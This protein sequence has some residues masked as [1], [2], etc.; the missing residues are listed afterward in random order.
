MVT[1]WLG[2]AGLGGSIVIRHIDTNI[3]RQDISDIT[4]INTQEMLITRREA[5]AVTSWETSNYTVRESSEEVNSSFIL[6]LLK[7]NLHQKFCEN[8][9][10]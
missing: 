10:L 1:S 3:P 7:L 4:D 5:L 2:V 8:I 9:C 6:I